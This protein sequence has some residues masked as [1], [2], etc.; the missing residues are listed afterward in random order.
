MEISPERL[1][2]RCPRCLHPQ[3]VCLCDRIPTVPTRTRIVLVRH[4]LEALR[5]SNTARFAPLAL[6][7]CTLLDYGER[8]APF[9]ASV[10]RRPGTWLLFPSN[11]PTTTPPPDLETLVGKT[12]WELSPEPPEGG[13]EPFRAL[14]RRREPFRDV[15]HRVASATNGT[16]YVS[17]SGQPVFD[18]RKSFRGY[19]GV[20]RD[21]SAEIWGTTLIQLENVV[22]RVLTESD[23]VDDGLPSGS[24]FIH[25]PRFSSSLDNGISMR[26]S[27]ASGPP[28][29]TAQ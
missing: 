29:T 22:A 28:S 5:S 25:Q 18:E 13:W 23:N 20:A 26:P 24:G 9:D 21:V 1:A 17:F 4:I 8:G 10:L 6:P 15:L 11:E 19:R 7:G 2:G 3:E 12:S 14:L 16:R 27:S